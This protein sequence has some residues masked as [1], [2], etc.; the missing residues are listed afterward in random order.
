M[1]AGKWRVLRG[2]DGVWRVLDGDGDYRG[3]YPTWEGAMRGAHRGASARASA[4]TLAPD[5][6]A[7]TSSMFQGGRVWYIEGPV[8]DVRAHS[9][10]KI[11]AFGVWQQRTFR[12]VS[13][14]E[15]MRTLA[16]TLEAAADYAEGVGTDDPA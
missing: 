10:G 12:I 14:P 15:K 3:T 8:G 5:L 1:T 13:T 16:R 9:T 6:P 2:K 7:P 11:V 4:V